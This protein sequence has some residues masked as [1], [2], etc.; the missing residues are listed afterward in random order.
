MIIPRIPPT[1][2]DVASLPSPVSSVIAWLASRSLRLSFVPF[3][4]MLALACRESTA[5]NQPLTPMEA[6]PARQDLAGLQDRAHWA[7]GYVWANNPTAPSYTPS[8]FYSFNR[9]GGAIQITKPAGTTGRYL[10]RFNGLSAFLGNK[11]TLHVTGYLSNDNYCKPAGPSLAGSVVEV[12]CFSASTGAAVNAYFTVLVTRNYTDLAFAH[13]HQPTGNNYAPQGA[14]NPGGASRVFRSGVGVYQVVFNGLG[15]LASSNGGHVQVSGVGVGMRHCKVGSWGGSPNLQVNVRCFSQSGVPSDTKFNV[16]FLLPSDHLAYAWAN[17]PSS[18]NYTPSTFYSS[19][20]TGGAISI[21]RSGTGLYTVSWAGVDPQIFE[22][23]DVQVTAYGGG[24][25]QCKVSSWGSASANVRCFSPSG[26]L[27][28][29][30]Y[31]V[32]LGS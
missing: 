8:T 4:A 11:S 17:Q 12:R 21:S 32:L 15:T 29:A 25:A 10:V 19:N 31:T 30:F 16:L 14:W 23:G 1:R 26:A 27:V 18:P 13:A 22:G 24:N 20:P 5:P 28:D 3:V 9:T 7:D 2:R 6:V